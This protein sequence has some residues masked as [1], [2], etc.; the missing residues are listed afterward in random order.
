MASV[1]LIPT[2]PQA[3]QADALASRLAEPRT[4]A[5]VSTLLDHAEL[6]ALLVSGLDGLVS[7]SDTITDSLADGVSELRAVSEP[8]RVNAAQ[9]AATAKQFSALA[10]A[11]LEKLP[12]LEALLGSDLADPKVI[13]LASMASRAVIKGAA[14]ADRSDLKVTGIVGLLRALKDPDVS[15]ALAFVISITKALGKELDNA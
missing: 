5:A 12:V 11:L 2:E 9:L 7:R 15:R 13:E 6:L 10:P 1:S 3:D 14:Q 8:A 4:A